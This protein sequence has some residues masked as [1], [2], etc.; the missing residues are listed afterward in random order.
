LSTINTISAGPSNEQASFNGDRVGK[1]VGYGVVHV[2]VGSDV[3]ISVGLEVGEFVGTGVVGSDVGGFVGFDVVGSDVGGLVG[4]DVVVRSHPDPR[5]ELEDEL[6]L[7]LELD[8]LDELEELEELDLL[9]DSED[10]D[11]DPTVKPTVESKGNVELKRN[12]D[13]FEEATVDVEVVE[14]VDVVRL[15]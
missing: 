2:V 10:S 13:E 3:G 4:F 15:C 6:L 8:E 14:V 1:T 9:E 12:S 11:P 7:P 5:L